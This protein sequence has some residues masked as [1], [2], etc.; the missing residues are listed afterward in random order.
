M[1]AGASQ[2]TLFAFHSDGKIMKMPK[3]EFLNNAEFF[4]FR[5]FAVIWNKNVIKGFKVDRF[6][7]LSNIFH[8]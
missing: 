7:P 4:S 5:F 3:K 1:A 2:M 8:F 6:G